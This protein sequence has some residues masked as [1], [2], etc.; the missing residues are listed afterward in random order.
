MVLLLAFLIWVVVPG[1]EQG[2]FAFFPSTIPCAAIAHIPFY[3]VSYVCSLSNPV[4]PNTAF[5]LAVFD[6]DSTRI[7]RS[8]KKCT[9]NPKAYR[10]PINWETRHDHHRRKTH[11]HR[12]RLIGT[13]DAALR[14]CSLCMYTT[15]DDDFA[16]A[17]V[18]WSGERLR[19]LCSVAMAHHPVSR[20]VVGKPLFWVLVK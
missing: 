3:S 17:F 2:H 10:Q 6:V 19:S 16:F 5:G 18:H 9:C 20:C 1:G 14:R 15:N 11:R 4:Q 13:C 7:P 8:H 12:C